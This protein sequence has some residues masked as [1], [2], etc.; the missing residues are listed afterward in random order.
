MKKLIQILNDL[1]KKDIIQKYAIGGAVAVIFYTETINTI[2]V[3][4]FVAAPL[5]R[6]KSG[7]VHLGSIYE[8]LKKAGYKMEG[9]YFIIEG[10]PVDFIAAYDDLTLEA[11]DKAADKLYDKIKV[12]VF[13]PEYIAAIALQT[14]RNQD[15]RKIDLLMTEAKLDEKPLKDILKRH[16]LLEKWKKYV[17]G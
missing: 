16:G 15:L 12:K 3:D 13:S 5:S 9:Q 2:D 10:I 1:V 11:L 7:I 8:Y 17:N 6:S 4:V 14:G